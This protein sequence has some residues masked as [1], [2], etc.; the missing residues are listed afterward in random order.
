LAFGK[1]TILQYA[2]FGQNMD[3]T[4]TLN[5]GFFPSG[6][7]QPQEWRTVSKSEAV[8]IAEKLEQIVQYR[9]MVQGVGT[10]STPC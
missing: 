8:A 10:F 1:D 9:G 4:D 7:R 5:L 2:T 3:P 6:D